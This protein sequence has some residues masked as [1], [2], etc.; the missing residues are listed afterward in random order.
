LPLHGVLALSGALATRPPQAAANKGHGRVE[1]LKLPA[2]HPRCHRCHQAQ[3]G[4]RGQGRATGPGASTWAIAPISNAAHP[5]PRRAASRAPV[6]SGSIWP[7]MPAAASSPCG[8]TRPHFDFTLLKRLQQ[9]QGQAGG[10]GLWM[11]AV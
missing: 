9:G 7:S 2:H 3:R 4:P 6:S 11:G 1:M 10:W 8:L 5:W